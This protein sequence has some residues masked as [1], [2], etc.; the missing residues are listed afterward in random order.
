MLLKHLGV[1]ANKLAGLLG[2]KG[3]ATIYHI[4]NERNGISESFAYKI[5]SKFPDVNTEWLLTGEGDMLRE[6]KSTVSQSVSGN[7]NISVNNSGISHVGHSSNLRVGGGGGV[8]LADALARCEA[9][10]LEK[11]RQLAEKDSQIGKLLE[12]IGNKLK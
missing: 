7:N 8:A 9:Q 3:N 12:I 2:Y 10:L 1:N 5:S 6:D 11:D 4:L